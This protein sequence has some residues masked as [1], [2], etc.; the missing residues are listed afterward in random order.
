MSLIFELK[1]PKILGEEHPTYGF[2]FWSET[3]GDF[4]VMFNSK[5]GNI[6]PGTRIMAEE[7]EERTSKNGKDYLRLKK[8]KLEDSPEQP[9]VPFTKKAEPVFKKEENKYQKDVTSIPLDVWR[10]LIGIQ[11]VPEN[12]TQFTEFFMTVQQHANELLLMIGHVREEKPADSGYDKAKKT[13]EE[14]KEQTSEEDFGDPP[15]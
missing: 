2:T 15:Y 4:P 10:T 7:S 3:D 8:V 14:L 13:R 11:G 5:Q 1:D 9:K 6:L 12:E